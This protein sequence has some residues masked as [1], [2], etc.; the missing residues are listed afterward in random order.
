[1]TIAFVE[2]SETMG[3]Q[4]SPHPNISWID[5]SAESIPLPSRS[6]DAAIIMLA[7]HHFQDHRA[8]LQEAYRVTGGGQIVLFTYDPAKIA[9]FWLT[10]YFPSFIED[11]HET[12][13]PIS[14]LTS[15]LAS[16]FTS[17]VAEI[18]FPLPH[19][20]ADSFAAVGWGRPEYYLQDDIRSG[21]SSFSK[22]TQNELAEG[23]FKLRSDLETGVWNERYGHL[24]KQSQYDAGYRFVYTVA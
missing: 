24:R 11:V 21:I 2:P 19:N 12:F 15:E 13:L 17:E 1:M 6:A 14:A 23:L 20:L 22:I 9:S 5:A 7:F 18:T 3:K 16:V 10:E 8:A 4:A